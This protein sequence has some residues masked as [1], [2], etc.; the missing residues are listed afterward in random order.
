LKASSGSQRISPGCG[1]S[2]SASS[3]SRPSCCRFR[4]CATTWP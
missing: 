4:R 1:A 2:R 3:S